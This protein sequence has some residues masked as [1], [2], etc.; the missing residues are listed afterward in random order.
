M[1]TLFG[2]Q[3][4]RIVKIMRIIDKNA[5]LSITDISKKAGLSIQKTSIYIASCRHNEWII[6]K[7][8]GSTKFIYLNPAGRKA[9]KMLKGAMKG[10]RFKGIIEKTIEGKI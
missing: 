8:S 2:K 9:Y 6:E 5:G 7:E 3:H 10:A 1:V 4:K